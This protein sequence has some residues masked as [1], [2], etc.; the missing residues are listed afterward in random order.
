MNP[1]AYNPD[2]TSVEESTEETTAT[3]EVQ[4]TLTPDVVTVHA[5]YIV[6]INRDG[7]LSTT[8]V[9]PAGIKPI[10]VERVASVYDVLQASKE[11]VADIEGQLLADRVAKRV[12]NALTPA[13]EDAEAK[14]RIAQ[15]LADRKAE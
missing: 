10:T 1:E 13:D 11:V 3:E 2:S 14:A 5:A 9:Q 12:I 7:S 6:V 4:T 8:V 15:A